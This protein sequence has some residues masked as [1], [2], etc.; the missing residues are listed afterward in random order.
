MIFLNLYNELILLLKP[1]YTVKVFLR[2]DF[3][4]QFWQKYFEKYEYCRENF[5]FKRV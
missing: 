1:E 3:N 5:L 4:E 2:K